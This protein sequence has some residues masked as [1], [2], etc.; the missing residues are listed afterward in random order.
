VFGH[1]VGGIIAAQLAQGTDALV[2]YGTPVMRWLDCLLDSTERQ[3]ALRGASTDEV[4]HHLAAIRALAHAGE[5]NGRSA[6]YHQQLH[7]LDLEAAWRAVDV[8]GARAARRARLVV[9][10]GRSGAHRRAR[11]RPDDTRRSAAPRSLFGSSR[12]SRGEPARLRHRRRR[13][14]A[15]RAPPLRGSIGYARS[16]DVARMFAVSSSLRRRARVSVLRSGRIARRSRA[17][18]SRVRFSRAAVFAGLAGCYSN[19]PPQ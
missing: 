16:H 1:S 18:S 5:L 15:S 9:A 10:R 17:C 6:A 11:E 3:L 7:A 12:G 13:S 14:G 4:A 8:P 2:V 19:P